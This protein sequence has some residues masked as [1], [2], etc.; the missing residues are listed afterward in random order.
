MGEDN[1]NPYLQLG[2]VIT[3]QTHFTEYNQNL[4]HDKA[5]PVHR[6]KEWKE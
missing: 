1:Q 2:A 5:R 3:I 6:D 4:T